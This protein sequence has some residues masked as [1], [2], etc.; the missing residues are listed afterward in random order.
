V[1]Q[2]R[3]VRA[4]DEH[5]MAFDPLALGV[6]QVCH[7]VQCHHGLAGARPT[8]DYQ[9]TRMIEPDDLVLLRL[10]RRD[11]VAHPVAARRVDSRQ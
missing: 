6:E 8:L 2:E 9:H 10:D 5:T 3:R 4:D 7:T 1:V 11:D